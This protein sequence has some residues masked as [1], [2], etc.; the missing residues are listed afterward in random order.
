[1]IDVNY[2]QAWKVKSIGQKSLLFGQ[3][4]HS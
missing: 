2:L 3:N 4:N 1:M